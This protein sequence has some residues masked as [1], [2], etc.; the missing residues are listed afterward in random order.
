MTL[1]QLH[2]ISKKLAKEAK[3]IQKHKK[4]VG[5]HNLKHRTITWIVY[6]SIHLLQQQYTVSDY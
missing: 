5:E 1:G 6:T 3:V 2:I 4:W